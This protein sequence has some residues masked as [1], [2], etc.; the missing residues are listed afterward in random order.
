[1][2]HTL[3]V[4]TTIEAAHKKISTPLPCRIQCVK[5]EATSW[6]QQS[7]HFYSVTNPILCGSELAE[8]LTLEPWPA[9]SSPSYYML[10]CFC[11]ILSLCCIVQICI[12]LCCTVSYYIVLYCIVLYCIVLYCIVLYCIVLYCIVL[13]CIVLYCIVLYCIVLYCIVML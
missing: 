12:P 7:D 8:Q 2:N 6:P 11:T 13:Y 9:K 5:K 3:D 10:P 4:E 1:M